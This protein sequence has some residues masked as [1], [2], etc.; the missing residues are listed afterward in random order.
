MFCTS[1]GAGVEKRLLIVGETRLGPR[2]DRA[3]L[4]A[5]ARAYRWLEDF[6][7]GRALP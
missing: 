2:V 4:K 7:A 3:L 6:V 1:A 5:V